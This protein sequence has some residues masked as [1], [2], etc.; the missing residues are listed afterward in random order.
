MIERSGLVQ[1]YYSE[2]LSTLNNNLRLSVPPALSQVNKF[3]LSGTLSNAG[4]E[5]FTVTI[6]GKS[7]SYTTES[8]DKFQDVRAALIDAIETDP[9]L[10]VTVLANY[11]ND[12]DEVYITAKN[13]GI[14]FTATVSTDSS[15]AYI[16][17]ES[18]RSDSQSYTQT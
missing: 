18:V 5:T 7:K 2:N 13:P 9:S 14:E 1:G 16:D 3:S 12:L 4:A 8:G 15:D 11:G 6:N 10:G 17:S